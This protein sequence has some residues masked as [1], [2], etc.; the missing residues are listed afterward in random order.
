MAMSIKGSQHV[1]AFQ[2]FSSTPISSANLIRATAQISVVTADVPIGHPETVRHVPLTPS[3]TPWDS[4]N[5]CQDIPIHC[6]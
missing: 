3:V 1:P 2:D 6:P 4:V 5:A